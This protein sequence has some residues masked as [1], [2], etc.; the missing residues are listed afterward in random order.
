MRNIF[1]RFNLM[2]ILTLLIIKFAVNPALEHYGLKIVSRQVSQYYEDMLKGPYFLIMKHLD[3]VPENQIPD[4][5]RALQ[6]EF[7]FPVKA[8]SLDSEELEGVNK[9]AF[10]SGHMVSRN[11]WQLYYKRVGNTHWAVRVGPLKDMD[12]TNSFWRFDMVVW[13]AL[14]CLISLISLASAYP[15]WKNLKA[16]MGAAEH[17]GGGD[18][19]ARADVSIRSPLKPVAETFNHMASRIGGM[20]QSQKLLINAVSH[21]LRTP[22]SRMRFGMEMLETTRDKNRIQKYTSGIMDDLDDLD[23]LVSELLTYAVFD[24]EPKFVNLQKIETAA[25][26]NNLAA[27]LEPLAGDKKILLNL[28]AAPDSFRADA[29]LFSRALENLVLNGLHYSGSLVLIRVVQYVDRLQISVIDDGPGIPE[30][31]LERIFEPFVRLDESRS[32]ESGG[33]GLGLAIV[34][35]IITGHKGRVW[36]EKQNKPGACICISL[37]L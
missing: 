19:S 26:F 7:G 1:I 28:S 25:W 24:R 8:V 4:K 37:G 6:K 9:S 33:V 15:F 32:R 17:F 13:A 35:Q 18:F 3:N 5:V 16:L 34:R 29:K 36:A 20:I 2:V 10:A 14:L 12:E 23:A 31:D 27:K 22:I 21:E 30:Q 11:A